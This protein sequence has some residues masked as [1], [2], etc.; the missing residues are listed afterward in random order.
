MDNELNDVLMGL[1]PFIPHGQ[2]FAEFKVQ[3]FFRID[4]PHILDPLFPIEE[5]IQQGDELRRRQFMARRE[6]LRAQ[7][8]ETE[9]ILGELNEQGKAES[10]EAHEH[11]MQLDVLQRQLREI[12]NEFRRSEPGRAQQRGRDDL[13]REVQ[14]LRK[15]MDGMNEQMD[16]MRE[17][18]KRLLEKKETQ[19]AL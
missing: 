17:L 3:G 12:E 9:L 11:R 5:P 16:E 14:N 13:E 1:T 4:G 8:R 2:R 15:Q 7:L 6:Q 18:M 10:E 19:E